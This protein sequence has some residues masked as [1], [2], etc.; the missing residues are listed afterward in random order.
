MSKRISI[1]FRDKD[2]WLYDRIATIVEHKQ[3]AGMRTS[4]TFEL[5]RLAK[6]GLLGEMRGADLDRAILKG[7]DDDNT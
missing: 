3:A 1:R 2:E 4:F 5:L 6:N 7:E